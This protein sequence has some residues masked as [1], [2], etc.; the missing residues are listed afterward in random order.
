VGTRCDLLGIIRELAARS[1][2]NRTDALEVVARLV[3]VSNDLELV[4]I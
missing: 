3:D 2:K 4:Y 1:T